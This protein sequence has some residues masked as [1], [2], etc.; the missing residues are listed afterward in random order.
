L[1]F[2]VPS[3]IA[4]PQGMLPGTLP[5]QPESKVSL[6]KSKITFKQKFDILCLALLIYK[7]DAVK[8]CSKGVVQEILRKEYDGAFVNFVG[9]QFDLEN[10]DLGKKGWT[11]YYPFSI[12][13]DHYIVRVFLTAERA[14]QPAVTVLHEGVIKSPPVTFQ[15][16]PGLNSILDQCEIEPANI[17]IKQPSDESI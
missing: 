13:D 10:I 6:T 12:Y 8:R 5:I 11:R 15:I 4:V 16:L 7:L 14:Y 1:L 3:I 17:Y 9:L 2:L